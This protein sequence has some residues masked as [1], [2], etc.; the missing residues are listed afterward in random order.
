MIAGVIRGVR[1]SERSTVAGVIR[2]IGSMGMIGG[3]V[4]GIGS[5]SKIR[6][7]VGCEGKGTFWGR[8]TRVVAAAISLGKGGY[9]SKCERLSVEA[10]VFPRFS[11][12]IFV[13]SVE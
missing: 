8:I 9:F 12:E 11:S 3:M 5:G 7:V 2:G 6:S 1:G 10:Q 13:I 4:W